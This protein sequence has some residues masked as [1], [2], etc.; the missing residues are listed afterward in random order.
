MI[1]QLNWLVQNTRPDLYFAAESSPGRKLVKITNRDLKPLRAEVIRLKEEK[2]KV[3]ITGMEDSKIS[4]EVFVERG[5]TQIG[6]YIHLKNG[7][8][9][10]CP[11]VWK[12]KV[13]RRVIGLT[14]AAEVTSMVEAVVCAGIHKFL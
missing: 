11:I 8:G 2:C 14:L 9:N 1:G 13:A 3:T 7:Q 6:F 5:K 12:S 10:Q 4:I